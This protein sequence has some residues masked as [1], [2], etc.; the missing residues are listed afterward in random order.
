MTYFISSISWILLLCFN[1]G[2]HWRFDPRLSQNYLIATFEFKLGFIDRSDGVLNFLTE[3]RLQPAV[4]PRNSTED[5]DLVY[6]RQGIDQ[7]EYDF[8]HLP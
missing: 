7:W 2:H 3:G 5:N 6:I 1:S 4:V 8:T